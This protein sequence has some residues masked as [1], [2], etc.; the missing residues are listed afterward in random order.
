M[1]R[2]C[3]IRFRSVPPLRPDPRMETLIAPPPAVAV[4]FMWDRKEYQRLVR[5]VNRHAKKHPLLRFVT[6]AAIVMVTV[7]TLLPALFG[8]WRSV[9]ASVPWAL[10]VILFFTTI[11][12]AV[13]WMVARSYA[14]QHPC[15]SQPFTVELADAELRTTCAHADVRVQWSGM[16]RAVETR[17]FF[18]FYVTDACAHY[19]P[20]R[21]LASPAELERARELVLRHLPLQQPDAPR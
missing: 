7:S 2:A 20:K 13:P 9:A 10:A 5:Q 17:E 6:V 19:L 3:I 21:A 8:D 1:V 4:S 15:V 12:L 11:T 14:R 16:R 18:L